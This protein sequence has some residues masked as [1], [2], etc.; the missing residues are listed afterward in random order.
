MA[1]ALFR[2][3]GKAA[4]TIA[5]GDC[6]DEDLM[7]RYAAGEVAAFEELL[8]RH[9][10]AVFNFIA[11]FLGDRAAAEDLVQEVFLRVIKVAPRYKKKA[12][13]RTWLFTI[14]RNASID[15]AR[16]LTRRSEVSL[17]RSVSNDDDGATFLDQLSD[18]D[19]VDSAGKT[20]RAEFRARLQAALDELPDAQREVFAMREFG[21][22]KF[23]E[24]A[25]ALGESENTIKSRMRYALE[26]LRGHLAD[27]REHSFDAEEEAR[28]PAAKSGIL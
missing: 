24:I 22:L 15:R 20:V 16:R 7:S 6:P 14:A 1:L 28:N 8:R 2:R 21:G 9:E 3:K 17:N 12:K 27:Y 5:L 18:A 10:R 11:R 13:F 19:A 23:R 25:E 26:A 4:E